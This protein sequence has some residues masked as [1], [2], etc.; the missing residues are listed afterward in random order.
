MERL[1][2]EKITLR[3]ARCEDLND[4]Y[5]NV[6]SDESLNKLMLW[7]TTTSLDEAKSRLERTVA[8]QSEND[9]FFI[10]DNKTKEVIGFCGIVEIDPSVYDDTGI[11]IAQKFQNEG[12]GKELIKLLS[13]FV[14]NEKKASKLMMSTFKENDRMNHILKTCGFEFVEAIKMT[15]QYDGLEYYSNQYVLT[16]ENYEN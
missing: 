6:W 10:E 11:C 3:K 8:Y 16:K 1:Q 7:K 13:D 14:F 9:A 4:I 5:T 2:G 12:R 15:R